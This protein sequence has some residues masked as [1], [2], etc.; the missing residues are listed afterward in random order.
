M[1][2][3]NNKS[4]IGHRQRLRER[5]LN[6]GLQGFHDYEVV[7]L[8]LTLG[9]PRS[10]CKQAAKDAL[11]KFGSLNAVLEADP[12]ELQEINGIGPNNVFGLKLSQTVARRYLAN[13]VIGRDIVTSSDEV[14]D[15]LKHNLRDKK[16]EIF[17]VIYLNGRNEIIGMEDLFHGSLTTSAIYP[18]EVV[19]KVLKQNAAALIFVHNHPSGNLNPSQEDINITKKLQDAVATIDVKVQDH[20]IIAGNNYY[21]FADNNLI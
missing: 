16:Q 10:D 6:S 9:T 1:S 15:Y 7:E 4:K 21:S 8:L 3:E 18:R 5:F 19:K 12:K 20:L 11:M 14:L 2:I 13:R 17:S